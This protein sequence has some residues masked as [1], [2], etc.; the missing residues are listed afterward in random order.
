MLQRLPQTAPREA[1]DDDL[2]VLPLNEAQAPQ[3]V[4]KRDVP[5]CLPSSA[6]YHAK[7]ID[8]FGLLRSRDRP[9]E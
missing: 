6:G 7:F 3:L 5:W 1:V 2:Q 9:P 8:P 4:K